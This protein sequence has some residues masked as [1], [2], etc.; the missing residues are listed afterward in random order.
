[1]SGSDS[2][3]DGARVEVEDG[4][5]SGGLCV[6]SKPSGLCLATW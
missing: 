4:T 2:V 6:I 1:V 5:D 3:A